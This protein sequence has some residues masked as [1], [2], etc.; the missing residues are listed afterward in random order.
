MLAGFSLVAAAVRRPV[1]ESLRREGT[2]RR[3]S[4]LRFSFMVDRPVE[5]VFS[6]CADFE[7]FPKFIGSLKEVQDTGD[8]RSHWCAMTPT[9]HTL[10]WNAVT[11]KFVTNSVIGW[12]SVPGS[13]V[14][15]KGVLRFSPEGTGTCVHVAI[16]YSVVDG[17][18]GDAIAALV[19]R[20]H[21]SSLEAEFRGF[22]AKIPVSTAERVEEVLPPVAPSVTA[23]D[24]AAATL[25]ST[26]DDA[27]A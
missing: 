23:S 25:A 20:R 14:E 27:I 1:T 13:P 12:K 10:E 26:A 8:G 7:N 3:S 11:S 5:Q 17:T 16:D 6:F 22:Q 4:S 2:R 15:T 19:M 9:G 18:L 21:R 24:T